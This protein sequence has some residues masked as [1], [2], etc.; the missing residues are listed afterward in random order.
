[1]EDHV[2][3]VLSLCHCIVSIETD[4][5]S[6]REFQEGTPERIA[7]QTIL[8]KARNTLQYKRQMRNMNVRYIQQLYFNLYF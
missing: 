7:L 3:E 5:I 4:D 8:P 2:I 1:M 6:I